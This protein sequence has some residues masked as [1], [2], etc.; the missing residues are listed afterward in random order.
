MSLRVAVAY[1]ASASAAA[2]EVSSRWREQ[3]ESSKLTKR[4]IMI[5]LYGYILLDLDIIHTL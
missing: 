5:G 2:R 4:D 1:W 3:L